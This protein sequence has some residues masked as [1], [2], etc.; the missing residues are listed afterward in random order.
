MKEPDKNL[1]DA[2][3]DGRPMLTMNKA[4]EPIWLR[5]DDGT[6]LE[7]R[8]FRGA[9]HV[10]IETIPPASSERRWLVAILFACI[11]VLSTALAFAA[12]ALLE[13]P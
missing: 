10:R 6:Q 3:A 5:Y 8:H 13:A 4:D 9:E 2:Y 12:S 7:I 11:I 1:Q